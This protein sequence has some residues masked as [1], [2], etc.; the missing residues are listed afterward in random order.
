[1]AE[2]LT[3]IG[4]FIRGVNETIARMANKEDNC[5]GRFWQGRFK[6]QALL[7]EQALLTCMAYVD[8]NPVCAG[9]AY[10]LIDSYSTSIQQRIFDF[11]NTKKHGRKNQNRNEIPTIKKRK[12]ILN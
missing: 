4:W 7:D 12:P 10:D 1:M 9:I 6:S 3:S 8:L 5:K 2:R 11:V